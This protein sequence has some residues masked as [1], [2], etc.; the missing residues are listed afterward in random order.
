MSVSFTYMYIKG[1]VM[2]LNMLYTTDQTDAKLK[3]E[4]QI[5]FFYV[6]N[7]NPVKDLTAFCPVF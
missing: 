5:F 7:M 1:A 6:S 2:L 4:K 3:T